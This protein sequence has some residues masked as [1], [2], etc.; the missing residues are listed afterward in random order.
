MST[1]QELLEQD[2]GLGETVKTASVS[3]DDELDRLAAA[4][5]LG[6][7]KEAKEE[8]EE[9]EEEEED[10]KVDKKASVGLDGMYN[11]LFPE[12]ALMSKTAE[13]QEKIAYEQ[14]LG[15]RA[16]DYYATRFDRRIEKLAA[17]MLTGGATISA[18]TAADPEG[19]VHKDPTIP[20]ATKDNRPADA[21]Q[22]S[23]IA[24]GVINELPK[25]D[26]PKTV[27]H[28]EMRKAALI[29]DAALR[30]QWLLTQLEN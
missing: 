23:S 21:G 25:G 20:Q 16:F 27:G 18:A 9:E 30:K 5:G 29:M 15:G 6:L 7:D 11:R 17:D 3:S 8:E 1:L 4:L 14:D 10:K 26:E 12:D 22:P 19:N 2:M 13:E 24:Q 28:V